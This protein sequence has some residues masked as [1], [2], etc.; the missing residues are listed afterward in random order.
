MNGMELNNRQTTH[1]IRYKV[2]YDLPNCYATFYN[3]KRYKKRRDKKEKNI[4]RQSVWQKKINFI[5]FYIWITKFKV[6]GYK[7]E[8]QIEIV[9][10]F[11]KTIK[12]FSSERMFTFTTKRF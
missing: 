1:N 5:F 3:G 9:I 10:D 2:R 6:Y 7:K 8:N 11:N 4:M 12:Y